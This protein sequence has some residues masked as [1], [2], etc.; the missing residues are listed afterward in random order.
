MIPVCRPGQRAANQLALA[1]THR[2]TI[3]IKLSK[4]C[5]DSPAIAVQLGQADGE[6]IGLPTF[7]N[8]DTSIP[9]QVPT[10]T[11]TTGCTGHST[12]TREANATVITKYC[13]IPGC[14]YHH[15]F[16]KP[17]CGTRET[18]DSQ[19]TICPQPHR[20]HAHRRHAN[21]TV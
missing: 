3:S 7:V 2:L 8:C 14:R 12:H 19:D 17:C 21:R 13:T 11:K 9:E 20:I 4:I 10:L 1:K 5:A 6:S 16:G 18:H 15:G